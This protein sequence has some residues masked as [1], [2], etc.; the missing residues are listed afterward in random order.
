MDSLLKS[1]ISESGFK[2]PCLKLKQGSK[3]KRLPYIPKT[4]KELAL[5]IE[6]R[7]PPFSE[8]E[9]FTLTYFDDENES[10]TISDE[11]DYESFMIFVAEEGIKIPK[12]IL[13]AESDPPMTYEEAVAD[14]NRTMCVSWMADSEMPRA[15]NLEGS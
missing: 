3:V 15:L 9:E 11:I 13:S 8:G 1:N 6:E 12:L 2:R 7:M 10:I 14:A 4:Y 5:F